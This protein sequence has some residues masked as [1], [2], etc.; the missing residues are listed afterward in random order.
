[1]V[2]AFGPGLFSLDALIKWYR[3]KQAATASTTAPVKEGA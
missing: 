3:G 2:L 1:V